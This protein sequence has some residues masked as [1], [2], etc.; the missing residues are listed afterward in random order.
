MIPSHGLLILHNPN[1]T[2]RNSSELF[3]A[4]QNWH[5]KHNPLVQ[6]CEQRWKFV[7]PFDSIPYKHWQL[8]AKITARRF[9]LRISFFFLH[10]LISNY[11]NTAPLVNINAIT[12]PIISPFTFNSPLIPKTLFAYTFHHQDQSEARSLDTTSNLVNQRVTGNKHNKKK[13]R[14]VSHP[15]ITHTIPS[16]LS[17]NYF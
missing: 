5:L 3:F 9:C 7:N 14:T 1:C 11:V 16:S 12:L 6:V 4:K 10:Q 13:T 8:S 2:I 15:R 17:S